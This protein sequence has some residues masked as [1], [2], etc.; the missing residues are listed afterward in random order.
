MKSSSP[1]RTLLSTLVFVLCLLCPRAA[2]P[3]PFTVQTAPKVPFGSDVLGVPAPE[4]ELQQIFGNSI[5]SEDLRGRVVVLDLWA[6][7]CLPC[8][9]EIPN[10]QAIADKYRGKNVQ[11]IGIAVE[12]GPIEDVKATLTELKIRYPILYGTPQTSSDFGVLGYPTTFV[13]T[14]NWTF[15]HKYLGKLPNRTALIDKEIESL[16]Q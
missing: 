3:S 11:V 13:L 7:W 1:R 5:K 6:T 8:S 2:R 10:L 9:D 12:S 4:F 14:R 16:L 15:H